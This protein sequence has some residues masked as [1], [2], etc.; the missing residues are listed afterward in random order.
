MA[1]LGWSQEDSCVICFSHPAGFYANPINLELTSKKDS[2]KIFYTEDGTTPNS[3]SLK[4]KEPIQ[5][6][7]VKAFRFIAYYNGKKIAN[8]TQSYFVN[9]PFSMGVVSIVTNPENFFSYDRG[10][11]VKG[12]CAA[13]T[14]PYNGANFWKNWEREI[15]IELFEQ[16]GTPAINQEAGVRI[17][18]GFSKG[19]PMKS[20]S[21]TARKKYGSKR[22]YYPIFPNKN[23]KKYKSF[24]LRNSGGDF[25][26]THFR[27]AL[28]TNLVEPLD[29]EI[30]AYRPVVVYINGI[31]WGIH[32]LREKINEHYLKYNSGAH[33]DS[34]DILKHRNDLQHGNRKQYKALIKYL[35]KTDLSDTVNVN[36]L[37]T[38]MD[39]DNFINYNITQIYIDNRDAGGN[40]RYWKPQNNTSKW[41]W[42]LFDTDM[43]FGIS[44]WKGYKTNT[45][46]QMTSRN[47]EAWP[48]PAWSTFIIRKLLENDSLKHKYINR[49]ADHL[50]SIFSTE[51]VLFKID[52][53]KSLLNEEMPNHIV[54]WRSNDMERWERNIGILRNFATYRP[55]Y[56][57]QYLMKQFE[58]TD[59]LLVEITPKKKT[60]G[61]TYLNSL[62]IKDPFSGYYFKEVPISLSAIP[63]YGYE[64][65]EWKGINRKENII[66]YN[67]TENI[68]VEPIFRKRA[69]ST[70]SQQVVINEICLKSDQK[71]WVEIYNNTDTTIDISNWQLAIDKKTIRF[72]KGTLLTPKQYYIIARHPGNFPELENVAKDSLPS[73]ISSKKGFIALLDLDLAIVDSYKYS[74]KKNFKTDST[75]FPIILE[76]VNPSQISN[77]ANWN[78][79][80]QPTIGERNRAFKEIV[81]KQES[82]FDQYWEYI[83]GIS[84]G[85]LF[86]MIV[87]F[88]I[89]RHKHFSKIG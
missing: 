1:T 17:F 70:W 31:Y 73:G 30:Q 2:I 18:G 82:L 88:L 49:F 14:T 9:R 4:Y 36:E 71:D 27:D 21:I 13:E 19:L 37:S 59:T 47:T 16:D 83:L 89:I 12:C 85:V 11:Y 24:I 41:R 8:Y 22:F 33:Q 84:L 43:S 55:A 20:L 78:I 60:E 42:I 56:L 79:N 35:S 57:R 54:K 53:T 44:D 40:I 5:I 75:F 72:G 15:N 25:N 38:F 81:P 87:I 74:V 26:K 51:N 34:V 63:Y 39:I 61:S 28:L 64:F 86:I 3:S 58:L 65:V 77:V 45:L 76:K 46:K 10:I 67:L 48:N 23:I 6:D 52:S 68:K 29:M 32:N 80:D 7:T 69:L 50:N 66:T 62:K